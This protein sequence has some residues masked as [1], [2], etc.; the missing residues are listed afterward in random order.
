MRRERTAKGSFR[1]GAPGFCRLL[2]SLLVADG[3]IQIQVHGRRRGS[4]FPYPSG[5]L[6]LRS[7]GKP[8]AG[9]ERASVR[10]NVAHL[11]L[12]AA[13]KES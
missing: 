2:L 8:C 4:R 3:S 10:A 12:D 6:A 11:N 9:W 5:A 7:Q 1:L 13:D